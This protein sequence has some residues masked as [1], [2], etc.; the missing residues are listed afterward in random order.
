MSTFT[1]VQGDILPPWW[2]QLLGPSG[3]PLDLHGAT[4]TLR[5]ALLDGTSVS[6]ILR[7][8]VVVDAFV[9]EVRVDWQPGDTDVAGVYSA[10]FIVD[11]GGGST[12]TIPAGWPYVLEIVP[13]VA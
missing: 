5:F 10:S 4:V 13:R 12:L 11:F 3:A 9:G 7:T 8:A 6:P 1:I 2:A